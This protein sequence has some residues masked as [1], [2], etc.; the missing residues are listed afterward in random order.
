MVLINLG[1]L[2]LA[3]AVTTLMM[4]LLQTNCLLSAWAPRLK[5][6]GFGVEAIKSSVL[7]EFF[8]NLPMSAWVYVDDLIYFELIVIIC[9]ILLGSLTF[10]ICF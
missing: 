2:A 8:V 7:S 9:C 4:H 10:I 5:F 1:R 6:V 3:P